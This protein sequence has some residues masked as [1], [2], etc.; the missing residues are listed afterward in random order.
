[1]DKDLFKVYR[2]FLKD[3]IR[4]VVDF[5]QTDQNRGIKP[6][7]L[8]KPFAEDAVRVDLPRNV[9][10]GK[11]GQ[12]DLAAAIGNRESRRAYR[13]SPLSL[14][15][16]S[17]LLWATQGVK[18]KLDPGHALR[19][20]PSAGCRHALETYLVI[21]N[22]SG[23]EQGVYRYLPLEH[24]LLLEFTEKN[25]ERKIVRAALDQPYPGEAAVTF[26]WTAVPYRMEWRYGLA[27]HK[28]IALDA[29]HVCQNLYLACEAIGAGACAIGAYDQSRMDKLL[30]VDGEE[31][32]AIYLASVGR[33][34]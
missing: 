25:L 30:R 18:E 9:Q 28:V 2:L 24:Q 29:G 22:V 16:M 1:M 17:F 33:R 5:S 10:F 34:N 23:M 11:I 7:P 19:T 12:I 14:D 8:E 26:V 15:E 4:K 27:A 32:F 20:V 3:S 21:L 13:R 31:E 6:P